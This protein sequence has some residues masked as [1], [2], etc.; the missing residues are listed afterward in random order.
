VDRRLVGSWGER[1]GFDAYVEIV[2]GGI[3]LAP[4][5]QADFEP[6]ALS[7]AAVAFRYLARGHLAAGGGEFEI[8]AAAFCLLEEGRVTYFEML[9]DADAALARFEEIGAPTE[10]ERLYARVCRSANARDWD[11]VRDCYADDVKVVDHRA[12]GWED[13]TGSDAIVELFQS[14]VDVAPDAEL[15]FET[16]GGD[17]VHMALRIGGHGHAAAGG[18]AYQYVTTLV[19]VV[20]DGRIAYGEHFGADEDD[21]ALAR[22]EELRGVPDGH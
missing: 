16:L 7:H 10:P 5:I 15:W 3:A 8:D 13:L 18:G 4:D 11:A 21:A 2:T 1:E 17:D 20:R 6:L 19:A 22:L 9:D 12:I 14:W